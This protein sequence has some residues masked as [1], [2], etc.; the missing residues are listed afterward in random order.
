MG[1]VLAGVLVVAAGA[2]AALFTA[3]IWADLSVLADISVALF[4]FIVGMELDLGAVRRGGRTAISV[5]TASVLVL[6]GLGLTD[7]YAPAGTNTGF[8]LFFAVAMS[9]T[10]LP[11]LARIL[12]DLGMQ[13]TATGSLV[14]VSAAINDVLAWV[15][16]AAAV[17]LS[18]Q[19][20]SSRWALTLSI[21]YLTVML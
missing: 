18:G 13:R 2:G 7:Q 5:A 17:A 8:L 6:F 12:T 20:S 4:M 11:V 19:G 14:L 10:A 3:S 21:P 16:L 15:L 9:V 1:E